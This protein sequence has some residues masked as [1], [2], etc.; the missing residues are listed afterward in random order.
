MSFLLR[1]LEASV[2]VDAAVAILALVFRCLFCDPRA[3]YGVL[4]AALF[5]MAVMPVGLALFDVSAP[6]FA[7]APQ[8]AP[9]YVQFWLMGVLLAMARVGIA[10]WSI[11]TLV[12]RSIPLVSAEVQ[13]M[14]DRLS[15]AMKLALPPQ[16]RVVLEGL[17]PCM[18]GVLKPVIL[19][20]ASLISKLSTAELEAI[21]AHEMSHIRR[22]DYLF[23]LVQMVVESLLFYHPGVWI[24]SHLIR[25]DRELCCDDLALS[26]IPD[27]AT[28]V[29]ALAASAGFT[30]PPLAPA[31]I[32]SLTFRLRRILGRPTSRP[33]LG[34]VA[35]ISCGIILTAMLFGLPGKKARVIFPTES[36]P[37][38]WRADASIRPST[39]LI[40]IQFKAPEGNARIVLTQPEFGD[41]TWFTLGK[42]RF[43]GRKTLE[44]DIVFRKT[45]SA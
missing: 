8:A 5:G 39:D 37:H 28:Y 27:R 26:L 43:E 9:A 25:V 21:L 30:H 3:R 11:R 24:I 6:R 17:S 44:G 42:M 35:P 7:S 14:V 15:R 4:M 22:W 33:A 19:I 34:I 29:R 16:V 10:F 31:L 32:G 40:E 45:S 2:P 12:R 38:S 23:S 1:A 18:A 20:P 41:T 13:G 36:L